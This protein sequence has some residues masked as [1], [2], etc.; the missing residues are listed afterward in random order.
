MIK[1]ILRFF[2]LPFIG[3]RRLQFFFEALHRIAIK[4]MNALNGSDF[5]ESGEL[6]AAQYIANRMISSEDVT[7]FDV[8]ANE[9]SYSM[10][11]SELFGQKASI[12]A[13]EPA[14]KTFELLLVATSQKENIIPVHIGMSN[15]ECETVLYSDE[16]RLGLSSVYNRKLGHIGIS[17]DQTEDIKLTT[18]D[19][20]CQG[21]QIAKIDFLKLDIEGHEFSALIGAKEMIASNNIDF[22]QFEF[23]GC[24]IDSRTY[25]K[26]FFLLL[27][28]KYRLFRILRDGL[29][30]IPCYNEIYEIFGLMNF[31]AERRK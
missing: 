22:I 20:Y 23:S 25:F 18:I 13:F 8:G 16:H 12:F 3:K 21:R 29:F 19:K 31:L 9:G 24:N 27:H 4:G 10:Y 7:I 6:H 28:P 15:R 2:I 14:K 1:R 5:R 11:L 26:D 17:L 30:E